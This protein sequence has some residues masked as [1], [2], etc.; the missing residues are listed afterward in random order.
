[1]ANMDK[2]ELG[3]C[4]TV[5]ETQLK[6]QIES[7]VIVPDYLPDVRR[8][9]RVD[10][11]PVAGSVTCDKDKIGVTGELMVSILY[12]PESSRSLRC[13][14]TGIPIEQNYEARGVN[15]DCRT[16]CSE[17]LSYVGCKVLN[18]RKLA[19]SA[20]VI[21]DVMAEQDK[22]LSV[23]TPAKCD[24]EGV[25][26]IDDSISVC[27]FVGSGEK[28]FKLDEDI[29]IPGEKTPA[30]M[31][32][33]N[34][35][36]VRVDEWKV[37]G[38][39]VLCKGVCNVKS[40]YLTDMETGK[41]DSISVDIPFNQIVDVEGVAE[42]D[43]LICS[44]K[45][46]GCEYALFED[47]KGENRVISVSADLALSAA[48]YRTSSVDVIMD[49]YSP[50]HECEMNTARCTVENLCE[51]EP[52]IVTVREEMTIPSE[53]EVVINLEG[54]AYIT[55]AQS[56]NGDM[57]VN[58]EVLV[59]GI[60]IDSNGE[61]NG[62][63]HAIPFTAELNIDCDCK[64]YRVRPIVE[65][66]SVSY[67]ITSATTLEVRAVLRVNAFARCVSE[68]TYME[69]ISLSEETK[70]ASEYLTLYYSGSDEKLWDIAK[71]YNTTVSK[72]KTVNRITDDKSDGR[73]ILI[74]KTRV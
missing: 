37:V 62:L 43:S 59:T 50:T 40:L 3:I 70:P 27:Q 54:A 61:L 55:N 30:A 4:Q 44:G 69:T 33:S 67:V 28:I 16:Q 46:L 11:S 51:V 7:E 2:S 35:C 10:A 22:A 38:D 60:V 63:E 74:P 64:A 72:I 73:M 18:S 57:V 31:L 32:C 29:D 52:Q 17:K 65:V 36:R 53:I 45:L 49:A 15:S 5:L 23:I 42:D 12:L 13:I 14:R 68:A 25:E 71:R 56:D 41:I 9:I 24:A 19:V 1:M 48:A 8:I 26:H 58:G 34:V 39:K 66:E 6:K 21:F 47:S 20:G